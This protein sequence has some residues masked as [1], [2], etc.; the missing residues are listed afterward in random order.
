MSGII[1]M[2]ANWS[3]FCLGSYW[4]LRVT[5]KVAKTSN[6]TRPNAAARIQAPRMTSNIKFFRITPSG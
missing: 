1:Q 3:A 2:I 5:T 6:D 4:S